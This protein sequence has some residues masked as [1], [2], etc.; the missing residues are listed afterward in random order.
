MRILELCA[1]SEYLA[2]SKADPLAQEEFKKKVRA[3][4]GSNGLPTRM[5]RPMT[6]AVFPATSRLYSAIRRITPARVQQ[7]VDADFGAG[8]FFA[9]DVGGAGGVVAD[10]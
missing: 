5:L 6:T 3:E 10:H 8:G 1:Q 7:G 2:I 9:F 4:A